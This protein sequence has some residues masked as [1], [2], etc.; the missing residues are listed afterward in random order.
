MYKGLKKEFRNYLHLLSQ[1]KLFNNKSLFVG[2]SAGKPYVE[3]QE[4]D[5]GNSSG[6]TSRGVTFYP[7]P[8]TH[9]MTSKFF[10]AWDEYLKDDNNFNALID[11]LAKQGGVYVTIWNN[12]IDAYYPSSGNREKLF[13]LDVKKQM[14]AAEFAALNGME[15]DKISEDLSP[16]TKLEILVDGEKIKVRNGETE[17]IS[18]TIYSLNW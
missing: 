8:E 4:Y 6:K 7:N 11:L 1:G 14:S 10:K 18:G 2:I 13:K 9:C 15:I 16:D 5:Y 17:V 3:I 12:Y